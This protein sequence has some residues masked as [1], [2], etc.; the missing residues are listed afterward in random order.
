MVTREFLKWVDEELGIFSKGIK[1]VNNTKDE[2]HQQLY[3][4]STR[5]NPHLSKYCSWYETGSKRFPD[6]LKLT[7]LKLKMWYVSDGNLEDTPKITSVNEEDRPEYIIELF[8]DVG[9][10]VTMPDSRIRIASSDAGKFFQYIG[11][12]V[13]DFEY[14]W[15]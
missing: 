3:R 14:K 12:P 2:T 5:R 1:R 4:L 15:R 7:P 6:N 13:P 11:E 10:T 8:E 9:I